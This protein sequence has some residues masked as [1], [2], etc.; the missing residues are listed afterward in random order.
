VPADRPLARVAV[1]GAVLGGVVFLAVMPTYIWVEP[2]W[3]ALVARLA[4]ALVV[5]VILV[6]LR[7]ALA[8]RLADDGGSPLD[9]ARRRRAPEPEVPHHFLGLVSDLRAAL[10]HRRYFE[11]VWW[12][13]LQALAPR[14]LARPPLRPGRG[15][16][17]ASLREVIDD[18]ER[19]P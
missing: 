13:R 6:Q 9:E 15:P 18:L 11:E 3:R 19:R 1:R 5:G 7:R 10:R 12:P 17:L 4:A 16:S 8:D 2:P 14:A